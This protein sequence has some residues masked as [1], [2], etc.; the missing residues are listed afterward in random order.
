MSNLN[1]DALIH[2]F[3]LERRKHCVNL[4]E[5]VTTEAYVVRVFASMPKLV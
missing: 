4:I 2:P 3:F 5:P 1:T